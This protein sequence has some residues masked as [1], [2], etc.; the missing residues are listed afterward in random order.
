MNCRD[1]N[2][3]LG[4]AQ[5]LHQLKTDAQAAIT[6][7]G[8]QKETQRALK[9]K[10]IH[11]KAD[12]EV[13]LLDEKQACNPA[14]LLVAHACLSLELHCLYSVLCNSHNLVLCLEL[15]FV[16]GCVLRIVHE[17]LLAV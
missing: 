6:D 7:A 12:L 3:Q 14:L 17:T 16:H 13:L 11:A 1:L 4:D 8:K 9:R 10:L 15:A 5:H 2:K